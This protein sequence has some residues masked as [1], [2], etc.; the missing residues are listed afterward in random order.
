MSTPELTPTHLPWATLC[1]G[2]LYPPV[3]DFEF[4]LSARHWLRGTPP[5]PPPNSPARR[6]GGAWEQEGGQTHPS[7]GFACKTPQ[8]AER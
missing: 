2:R 1:Q 5:P 3:R 8:H 4:G 6:G 7:T